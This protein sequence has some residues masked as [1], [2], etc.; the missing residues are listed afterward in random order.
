MD[1]AVL[2]SQLIGSYRE[3][4]SKTVLYA[5]TK[6]IP[7][8]EADERISELYD[9]LLTAQNEKKP[10]EKLVGKDIERFCKEFFGDYTLKE[11]LKSILKNT[12]TA[13]YHMS[14]V[15][16]ILELLDLFTYDKRDVSF[17]N[18][19]TDISGYVIG[20]FGGVLYVLL[21]NSVFTR[22]VLKHK[23]VK[24]WIWYI[25]MLV[26]LL[27]LPVGSIV[28]MGDRAIQVPSHL[29]LFIS[30]GY[31]A[32]YLVVRSILRYRRY[33]TIRNVKK[34]L[35]EDHY[36]KNLENKD[37]EKAVLEGW[38]IR[39]KRLSRKNKTTPEGYIELLKKD[40]KFYEKTG[41]ITPAIF[42]V[43]T[44]SAILSNA[45]SSETWV[46]TLMFAAFMITIEYLIYRFFRKG[47]KRNRA[48]CKRLLNECEQSGKTMPEYI[49]EK[50]EQ[51]HA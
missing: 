9:L 25:L 41:F 47:E 7:A 36:Y 24:D 3:V 49:E 22:L 45:Q 50:L 26:V 48:L 31:V 5:C 17:F 34:Q 10:V 14:W 15:A 32:L 11:Q 1:Y 44:I 8:E 20:L 23:K 28:I 46:D 37:L 6:C 4:F 19:Q 21:L 51:F 39:Y 2:E 33:G 16:L 42:I 40:E 27:A 12:P 13:F 29:I 35:M 38:Q 43:L 30:G 18:M